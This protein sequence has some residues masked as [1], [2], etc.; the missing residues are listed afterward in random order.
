MNPLMPKAEFK[1]SA[2]VVP[3]SQPLVDATEV[4]FDLQLCWCSEV[5]QEG[6]LVTLKH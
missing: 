2:T 4:T 6:K 3:S 1:L 5:T